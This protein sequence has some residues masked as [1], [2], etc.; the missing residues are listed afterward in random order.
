MMIELLA[1][2]A[3]RSIFKQKLLSA[4]NIGGL[5]IGIA[6][7][8]AI[9]AYVSFQHSFDQFHEKSNRIYRLLSGNSERLAAIVPYT[10]GHA[11]QEEI[12]E[13]EKVVSFQNI[14]IALTVKQGDHY[15]SQHGF[16]GVDSTFLEIF[17]FPT[18]SG[19]QQTFLKSPDKMLITPGMAEKYFGRHD[20]IGRTLDV[21]LWGNFV[22]F[23]IEGVIDCP[24]NSHIQFKF[25]IP[26][27]P[28]KK[29]FFSQTAFSSWT[30]HFAHTYFLTSE[31][32]DQNTLESKMK[33]CLQR[34]GGT[35][36]SVKYSP[37]LQGLADIYLRS[38][39]KFDFLPRGNG[40]QLYMLVIVAFSILMM[41]I[42]NFVNINTANAIETAKATVVER[43]MGADR[44]SIFLKNAFESIMMV[45]IAS[46]IGG[47]LFLVSLP[48]FNHLAGISYTPWDFLTFEHICLIM[49]LSVIVGLMATFYPTNMHLSFKLVTVLNSR[50]G[51]TIKS[52]RYRKILVVVQFSLAIILLISTLIIKD[53][54]DYMINKDLGFDKEQVIVID[55]SSV[56]ASDPQKM[57]LF[58]ESLEGLPFVRSITASSSYPG[59]LGGHSAQ[60][61]NPQ[62]WRGKESISIWTIYTDPYF[63][64]TFG[65]KIAQGRDLNPSI[66]S[67]SNSL[68][69]NESALALFSAENQSWMKNPIGRTL[70]FS[71][72]SKG[73]VV[74]VLEDFHFEPLQEP[75]NPLVIQVDP[76]SAFSVQIRI[77]SQE[78]VESLHVI[79]SH[80]KTLFEETP[81]GYS[82][83]NQEFARY[84]EKEVKLGVMMRISTALS[85]LIAALGLFGLASLIVHQRSKEMSIR[86]VTGASESQIIRL[87][88]K[89]FMVLVL[90]ANGLAA[91]LGYYLMENWLENFAFRIEGSYF[92]FVQVLAMSLLIT[93][94]S[95]GRQVYGLATQNPVEVLRQ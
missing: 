53:Q 79:E 65:L 7:L 18:L 36:L 8:Y 61:Y 68:L 40:Q 57:S 24:A 23:E 22:T 69:I 82:L 83:L 72:G 31:E 89:Q 78:A 9:L 66:S 34:H 43:I 86:K 13:I 64:R 35:Q 81:F 46:I 54:V 67:D 44:R 21:N 60:H 55:G 74:G 25:L 39:A 26:I 3:W 27:E 77:N 10:W 16:I 76:V 91:P 38:T 11:M 19:D 73:K 4:I 17:D 62:G 84:F 12:A 2:L 56:V 50:Y 15:F 30:T 48:W 58:R 28:V 1:K 90:L 47:I 80:W 29:H 42:I 52:A 51:D 5:S 63:A 14:T 37:E 94:I 70:S 33:D 49:V 6:S 92:V 20:P 41:A 93:L 95:V 59:D 45:W 85:V 88:T 87:M 32:L 75:I 71:D